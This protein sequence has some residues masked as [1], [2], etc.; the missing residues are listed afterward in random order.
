MSSITTSELSELWIRNAQV[1]GVISTAVQQLIAQ[2]ASI[3]SDHSAIAAWDG[4]YTYGELIRLASS[5]AN[6][7]SQHIGQ[8]PGKVLPIVMSKSKWMPI[9]MVGALLGGWGIAPLDIRTP[10][11]R[12]AE[13]LDILDPPCILTIS[14]NTI[15]IDTT[16]PI[17]AVDDLGLEYQLFSGVE[18]LVENASTNIAA[19]V[20]TSGSTG[21][22]KGVMLS[23]ECIST[24]AVCGSQILQLGWGSR[25][26]QF[27]SYSFDISL[28][29][30]FMTLVAGGCLCIPSETERLNNL[31]AA[32][33]TMQANCICTTP[34]IV[35]SA[36]AEAIVSTP[37][38]LIVLTGEALTSRIGPLFDMDVS[39]FN[40]YGA[41]E[42]P[43]VSLAPLIKENSASS[44]IR[45]K[46]PGNCWVVQS[47]NPD[48]LCG[49]G[50]VGEL[51]VESP[52]LTTGYLNAPGQ[53]ETAFVVDP[54]WLT[55][56]DGSVTG[57]R[58]RLYRTGDLVRS[59]RDW[60][61]DYIGRKDT[62]VKIRGQRVDLSAIEFRIWNY[63]Q[64]GAM[65]SPVRVREVLVESIISNQNTQ[66]ASISLALQ[67]LWAETLGLDAAMIHTNISFLQYG[68]DSLSAIALSKA[69]KIEFSL[70]I[71]VPQLLRRE[72]T[73]Q[74]MATLVESHKNGQIVD[75]PQMD[76]STSL[77]AW[78]T[79]LGSTSINLPSADSLGSRGSQVLLT[80]ATGYLGTHILGELFNNHQVRKIIILV[81]AANIDIA[82]ERVRKVAVTAGWWKESAFSRIEVWLGDLTETRLGLQ[83]EKWAKMSNID[84]IIH[85]GAVVNYSAGYDVLERANVVSTFHLLEAA[86]QSQ[87]LRSF[88]FI[89]GGIKQ[90]L[91]QSNEE[92]LRTLNESEAYSQTKYVSEQLTLA[93]GRLYN[94]VVHPSS[95]HEEEGE[96]A[97]GNRTFIVIKPGY[98]IGDQ[99]A[100]LSNTDDYI[101]RMVAGAVRMGCFPSDPPDYWLDIAE[102]TYVAKY[103]ARQAQ[104]GIPNGPSQPM[105]PPRS[106]HSGCSSPS[107]EDD[108]ENGTMKPIVV[109][110]D[111]SRG[112]PVSE[113]WNAIQSLAQISLKQ[114]D[115]DSWIG[116]ANAEVD[117]D[118]EAHPL[119]AIQLHLGPALGDR[120]TAEEVKIRSTE[121]FDTSGEIEAAVRRSVE[122]LCSIQFIVL[123]FKEGSLNSSPANWTQTH[124]HEA[125]K[126]A[127]RS[128]VRYLF[129]DDDD[130]RRLW[131]YSTGLGFGV[132]GLEGREW[133]NCRASVWEV[134]HDKWS[135]ELQP[136]SGLPASA[137]VEAL[138]DPSGD[139]SSAI[140][141][142]D[143]ETPIIHS[144]ARA[145][146][147]VAQLLGLNLFSSFCNGVV[148][149]GLPAMAASLHIDEGLL[150]WP[151]S[152][153]YL[154]AG[155]CLL[156]A[157]SITD[158]IGTKT[159]ILIGA[160]AAAVSAM[161]C[162]LAQTGG[163]LIA[164]RALQGITNAIIVPSSVSI[165]STS[166]EEGRPRN[167]GFACLGFAGPIG[168]SLGLVL[169]GVFAD[170]TGWRAAFY[171]AAATTFALF[172][173]GVWTLP[174]AVVRPKKS[175]WS[176]IL[177]EVDI[178]GAF[179]GTASLAMLSYV[180]AYR[181]LPIL[182]FLGI[183]PSLISGA[184]TNI[185]TG[186]FVNRMPVMWSVLISSTLSTVAPLLMALISPSWPYWYDA[187]FAQILAPLS[188]DILFT[189]GLLVVSDVFPTHMQ[190]L[191]G[192]VFNTCAQLGTAIGLTVT[193][194][195]A[196]SV[197]NASVDANK[198]SPSALMAG[199]RAVFWTMFAA[200]ALVCVLSVLGL[201]TVKQLGVKRD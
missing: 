184:L 6:W 57:R 190:A 23:P 179:I 89:S 199:Y 106:I 164:F 14:E 55:N 169:G 107:S 173:V 71:Q 156:L 74:H 148:V 101:W 19:V 64:S 172:L 81:R 174:K 78:V 4:N 140:P 115:W 95:Q 100:G 132:L 122:Y 175:V 168:F 128:P 67:R 60:T 94:E 163:Q 124:F 30:T 197:T 120:I 93:A 21:S 99:V 143:G 85:N 151:T 195:I 72:T 194:L 38:K 111:M 125:R 73:I 62:M 43:V 176:R 37:I 166:L 36:L 13:I 69:L 192:A 40:W 181:S 3:R 68:G 155:S 26:F 142:E 113:F 88:I 135:I 186:I 46:H 5:L 65:E 149:V 165:I 129:H 136:A 158:V 109:F 16:I 66:N 90:G 51:L 50:E 52:M 177:K 27:S 171:L 188:C 185:S 87:H 123:P 76:I 162:G 12:L 117:R 138:H 187:F 39:L 121:E 47:D 79:R 146:F 45:S 42:C 82:R 92:Y 118:K 18:R 7:L 112:L 44:Q 32:I 35:M 29:E 116:Q 134:R 189:V 15:A 24:S 103:V 144:K 145:S 54:A 59:N 34:S 70:S 133:H 86:L 22:P 33:N 178:I 114:L 119:W 58:G 150:V 126:L 108:R 147:V 84:I 183:L 63:L 201:R 137:P 96:P 75:G 80:G 41:T 182:S 61:F 20:F 9:A 17:F 191:S 10:A 49:F 196:A 91:H 180:L 152:V 170:S 25:L 139:S 2:R 104:L 31:V 28:H 157:G 53:T 154:T 83:E 131:Y 1:P 193:S 97:N 141:A 159:M 110:H 160:L 77:E 105:T 8:H 198:A 153:F 127:K 98:I 102:V 167:L 11:A 161:A 200:M 130:E 48:V 56:G